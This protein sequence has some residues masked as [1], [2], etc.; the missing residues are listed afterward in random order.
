MD[1]LTNVNRSSD[2]GDRSYSRI[3]RNNGAGKKKNSPGYRPYAKKTADAAAR[4]LRGR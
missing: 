2:R 3:A 1:A 4:F